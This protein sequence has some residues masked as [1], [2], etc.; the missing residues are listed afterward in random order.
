M[1]EPAL[2][3]T[4]RFMEKNKSEEIPLDVLC[5]QLSEMTIELLKLIDKNEKSPALSLKMREVELLQ[6]RIN[7]QK[8]SETR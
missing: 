7:K 1:A 4:P 8:K 2:N 3:S 5:M 6:D